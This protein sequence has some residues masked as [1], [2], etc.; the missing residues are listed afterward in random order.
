MLQNENCQVFCQSTIPDSLESGTSD[1]KFINELISEGY[2]MNWLIDGL[3]A[4]RIRIDP[5]TTERFYSV[6]FELGS[7]D[8]SGMPLLNNHYDIIVEYHVC[9]LFIGVIVD[10]CK[11]S[12]SGRRIYC[13]TFES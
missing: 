2:S 3:P 4:A 8:N 11:E 10:F 12:I 5:Q 13:A 7:L 9:S 1:G 6:G